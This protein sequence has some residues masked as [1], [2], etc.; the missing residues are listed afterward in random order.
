MWP[1]PES[2]V[3]FSISFCF[4]GDMQS[5]RRPADSFDTGPETHRITNNHRLTELST[6]HGHCH[7]C[8]IRPAFRSNQMLGPNSRS[9]IATA[10]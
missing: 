8:L 1:M 9:K 3:R 4:Y 5:D 2:P 10:Q 7:Q 6:I